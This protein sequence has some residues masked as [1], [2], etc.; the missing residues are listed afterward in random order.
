[1][2]IFTT[3][4]PKSPISRETKATKVN[5]VLFTKHLTTTRIYKKKKTSLSKILTILILP[6][7][8]KIT[9]I[10]INLIKPLQLSIK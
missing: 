3:K 4:Y 1:M 9:I 6:L 7:L 8:F 10:P 5:L 2:I